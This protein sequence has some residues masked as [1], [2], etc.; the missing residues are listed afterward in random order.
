MNAAIFR[1]MLVDGHLG[2]DE[3]RI[4]WETPT[5]PDYIWPGHPSLGRTPIPRI[6]QAL[7]AL[8]SQVPAHAEILSNLGARNFLPAAPNGFATL[9]RILARALSSPTQKNSWQ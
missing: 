6:R 8:T 9:W 1:A 4:V 2:G 3:M 7:L 5:Y